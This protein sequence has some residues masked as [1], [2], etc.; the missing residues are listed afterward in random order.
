LA[1]ERGRAELFAEGDIIK[2]RTDEGT[3]RGAGLLVARRKPGGPTAASVIAGRFTASGAA[4]DV[5]LGAGQGS[6]LSAKGGPGPARSLAG[7]PTALAPGADALYVRPNTPAELRWSSGASAHHLQLLGV[8]SEEVLLEKD[9]GAPPAALEIPW[10][11][12][13][14]W[15]VSARAADGL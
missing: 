15:R 11:G 3:L 6:L 2:L 4:R 8:D 13:F 5:E 1:L 9:V 14:R 12:T 10:L 7:A